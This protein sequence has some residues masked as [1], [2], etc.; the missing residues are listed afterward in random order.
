MAYVIKSVASHKARSLLRM[1]FLTP[2]RYPGGKGKLADYVKDTYV[3]NQILGGHYVEPYAGGGAVALDMLLSGTTEHIHMNDIDP[4]IYSFWH[5]VLYNTDALVDLIERTDVTIEEWERQREI[6]KL[7][8]GLSSEPSLELGFAA[9]FLN[10][11]NRSGIL[12]A[13]V[14]GGKAQAGQWTLDV[15][16]NKA[17]LVQRI[18]RISLFSERISLYN[19]DAVELLRYLD[20]KIPEQSLIYLDPPYYV[21][22]Q[23]LYRNFYTHEDHV[24]IKDALAESVFSNWLVSYDN[25]DEIRD[26][27][28]A[29]PQK[30]YS[31]QY[32][33]QTKAVGSEVMIYSNGLTIT[34]TA[35][36]KTLAV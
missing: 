12:K 18:K 8:G 36:G 16:F 9:F 17:D 23:G 6:L 1:R 21:K 29:Y 26:I 10:R 27:Y 14:I 31:L 25:A 24:K 7:N 32:T 19:L 5:S 15:R 13:G 2:L 30:I 11:T 4:A 22:G 3:A 20:G 35:L 33:A 34:D 28:S